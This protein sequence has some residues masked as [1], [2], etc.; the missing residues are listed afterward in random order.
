MKIFAVGDLHLSGEPAQKPMEIF[1][2][3]WLNHWAQISTYWQANVQAQDLVLIAGDTSWALDLDNAMPDLMRIVAMPGRKVI[4]RGNHDYWWAT[5]SKMSKI[6]GDSLLFLQNN[7]Y[8][9]ENIAICGTRGW[10]F[11]STNNDYYTIDDTRIFAR[12]LLR[13]ENSLKQANDMG[14]TDKILVLHYP[15]VLIGS[16]ATQ[17]TELCQRYGVIKCI[18]GHLHGQDAHKLSFNGHLNGTDYQL[19][20]ADFLKFKLF[21]LLEV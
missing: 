14:Y 20:A 15:P 4:V 21:P 1:D 19:V 2:P 3:A 10:E 7:F 9:F 6:F 17:I 18:Y 11:P 16:S 8:A 5:I 13:I 12:E